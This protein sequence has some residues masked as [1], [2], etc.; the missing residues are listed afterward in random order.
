QAAARGAEFIGFP[1]L[2]LNGYHFSKDTTWLR[3]DGP[4]V[5]SVARKALEKR[6]YLSVGLAE[7]DPTGAKWNTQ[8][9]IDPRGQVIGWHHKTWLTNEKR[10]AQVG[11]DHN[12]FAVKGT[13]MGIAT[14]ADGTDYLN[15]K[16][17]ADRGARIIY[18]PHAN[19][20]GGT[21]AGWYRFRAKWGG[22]WD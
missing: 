15:L 20:T 6:V 12:V 8:I 9:V 16:A 14:C 10:L 7:E 4:E 22:P 2:S 5:Q 17:L 1:E 19:T 11:V 13:T 3:L 21:I 18:G